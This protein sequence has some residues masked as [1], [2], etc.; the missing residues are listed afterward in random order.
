VTIPGPVPADALTGPAVYLAGAGAAAF[1][2]GLSKAG[3]GGGIGALATPLVLV[4]VPGPTALSLMLPVLIGCDVFTL[5]RFPSEWDRRA[6][7]AVAPWMFA[8]LFAGLWLLVEFARRGARGDLWIRLAAG[9]VVAGLT[10]VSLL[11]PAP[12]AA[13][14]RRRAAPGAAVAA[15]TGLACGVT[16]MLAHAAGVLMNLYLLARRPTP[17]AFVGT[18]TRIFL[19]FNTLK[20]P[21][22]V[23]ATPLAGRPF[24]TPATFAHGLWLLPA[25]YAGVRLG[26]AL[27]RS[28]SPARY[29]AVVTA[30]LLATG[31]YLAAASGC[32]LAARAGGG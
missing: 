25:G 15:V 2:V 13:G 16:T 32:A 12:R 31:L 20:I 8:G 3:F 28:L 30:L 18:S 11:R 14:A 7:R 23:A 10:A 21:F 6:F 1:L 19:L 29:R 17:A 5:R 22:F 24:L 27:T 4:L 9:A 26:A